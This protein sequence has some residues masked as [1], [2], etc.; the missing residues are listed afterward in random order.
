M[1]GRVVAVS[2]DTSHR[3]SK[4]NRPAIRLIAGFG[5][6]GDAHA[7]AAVMHRN[8]AKSDPAMPN[9]RQVHLIQAELHDELK[10]NG[11]VVK[12]GDLG[13]N[14]TTRGVDLL[15][16]PTATLLHLGPSAVVEV[17]GVRTPCA[18][19]D[20]FQKGL[21][22]A[23][24]VKGPGRTVSFKTGIMGIVRASGDV[25]CDDAVVAELPAKPWMPLPFL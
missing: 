1:D 23:M 17:T 24:I 7:G 11:F 16:L 18:Q 5:V 8:L 20:R 2:C 19:I 25:K 3:F 10:D 6:E 22:R 14:V 12:P 4:P 13:E 9:L 15:G 21:K